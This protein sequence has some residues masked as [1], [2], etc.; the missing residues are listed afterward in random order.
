MQTAHLTT[1][2]GHTLT[3]IFQQ[4]V[5]HTLEWREVITLMKHLG[6]VEER[7]GGHVVFTIGE[8]SQWFHR[9]A[10]Q[11]V[12][13]EAQVL[14]L[15]RFLESVGI[16]GL[17]SAQVPEPPPPRLLAVVHLSETLLF[18]ALDEDTVPVRICPLGSSLEDRTYFE[19]IAETL[20][21][22]KEVLLMGSGAGVESA[23]ARLEAFLATHQSDLA[24]QVVGTLERDVEAL[25]EGQLLQEARAFF[26]G[27]DLAP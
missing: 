15:R 4:P 8:S 17:L 7:G 21:G 11:Q 22:V 27:R 9:A 23:M 14:A 18:R 6:T 20:T 2:F 16:G 24:K 26:A 13:P 25:T 3:H 12:L 19:R 10:A 5:S 1:K